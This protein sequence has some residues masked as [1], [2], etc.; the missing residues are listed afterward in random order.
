MSTQIRTL[1]QLR[2]TPYEKPDAQ[3]RRPQEV[4]E[5][6]SRDDDL[7]PPSTRQTI[8]GR[9]FSDAGSPYSGCSTWRQI[10]WKCRP[11]ERA[12][13]FL[14][15]VVGASSSSSLSPS[16][17]SASNCILE[18]STWALITLCAA[19]R[20]NACFGGPTPAGAIF[21]PSRFGPDA[22]SSDTPAQRLRF[23]PGPGGAFGLGSGVTPF[24]AAT[25]P[26]GGREQEQMQQ[27][28]AL[29][30]AFPADFVMASCQRTMGS[31]YS[32]SWSS[33]L[34]TTAAGP[35]TASSPNA[36][37]S[38]ASDSAVAVSPAAAPLRVL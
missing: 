25:A 12:S 9:S 31:S 38:V 3:A 1:R 7:P 15:H 11:T 21:R 28:V 23:T 37:A 16:S 27:L 36:L 13:N 34:S 5:T 10:A 22:G 18:L 24:S 26:V 32:S 17:S 4:P 6:T 2:E 8:A 30:M 20:R 19:R 29:Q 33:S 35:R 14:Q